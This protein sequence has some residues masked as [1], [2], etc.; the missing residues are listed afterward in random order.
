MQRFNHWR[1]PAATCVIWTLFALLNSTPA[2]AF[3]PVENAYPVG[4]P[5][6]H[7]DYHPAVQAQMT[8][9]SEP[10]RE[11]ARLEGGRWAVRWDELTGQA[12]TLLAP[13]ILWA[14]DD[15]VEQAAA[16]LLRHERLLGVAGDSLVLAGDSTAGSVR[17]LTFEQRLGGV[18]VDGAA[19]D[20]RLRVM[21]DGQH[22]SMVRNRCV[23]S[24]NLST[25]ASIDREEA[26]QLALADLA[27]SRI[28]V[29]EPGEL[30]IFGGEPSR[31][32]RPTLAWRSRVWLPAPQ[33]LV[34]YVDAH[35][36]ALLY[37]YDDVRRDLEGTVTVDYE[38][39][40]VDDPIM[41]AVVPDIVVVGSGG[42]VET[43]AAGLFVVPGVA[44]ED[45]TTSMMGSTI[46]LFDV[47]LGTIT[48]EDTFW[49]TV[50]VGNDFV[51]E[52]A[53][54]TVAARDVLAHFRIVR[55]YAEMRAPSLSWLHDAVPTTVN[56]DSGSCNAYY[57]NGTMTFYAEDP[58]GSCENFGRVSD[59]VYHEYGHGY[60]HYLIETGGFDGTVSEGSA[61]YL[62]STI[63]D[64]SYLGWGCY[65]SG[66]WIRE[67][68]T[69]KVYPVDLVGEVHTDGL[70]W[71]SALWDLRDEMI[72]LY[73]YESGVELNDQLFTDVLRG[74]PSLTET[75][76]ELILADDDNGDLTDGTPHLCLITEVMGNHGLGPGELGYFIYEH[77]SLGTQPGDATSYPVEASFLLVE[78]ACSDFD[79][80][81][82]TLYHSMDPAGPFVEV[83]L[84]WDG[85]SGYTGEIPRYP[86]GA[87]VYYYLM[88][89]DHDAV[90]VFTT[91]D[92]KEEDLYQFFVGTL[93]EIW[94][95]D[96]EFTDGL[97]VHGTGTP[98]APEG[99]GDD[100]ERAA[101]QGLTGDPELATSGT[102]VWG[103]DLSDDGE[104]SNNMTQYLD[105]TGVWVDD[106]ERV[107]LQ[108]QRWLT[109]EDGFY[110][111]ARIEVN[112]HVVWENPSTPGG[113]VHLIDHEWGL[114]DL[115][116]DELRDANDSYQVTWTLQSDQGLEYGGWTLDDVCFVHLQ[117][118][119]GLYTVD[120]FQASDFEEDQSTLT[121]TNPWVMPMWT[122]VVVRNAAHYPEDWMDGVM[123]FLDTD[124]EWGES[125][126]IVDPDLNPESTYYYAVFVADEEWS[127]RDLVVEGGNADTAITSEPGDDDSADDDDDDGADD[128]DTQSGDPPTDP[129]DTIES[130]CACRVDAG[131]SSPCPIVLLLLG[132]ILLRGRRRGSR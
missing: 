57:Y 1:S 58:G 14:Q 88:A 129:P 16:F 112:G 97:F 43:D 36:G 18:A 86:S 34:T 45:L 53:N 10:F 54:A 25:T 71:A 33:V 42:S 40:T 70:I 122:V 38:E 107:R 125:I 55:D 44:D 77:D 79:P 124:P 85:A 127:F 93:D 32:P 128:D 9:A 11:L 37:R 120:D 126:E 20:F 48:P 23:V 49:A 83:L 15:A 22:L 95:D 82:V 111:H 21:D 96:M 8:S 94:C 105:L 64:D 26:L 87:T 46:E 56:V 106:A 7:Q 110:D 72:G 91:H 50:G 75:Y 39:R 59:V 66:T 63:W 31:G 98:D 29:L 116:V 62:S 13:G 19:V 102:M 130:D 28:E 76:D 115:D 90:T 60:H 80:E 24:R 3:Q 118:L 5:A 52:D 47:S 68:D 12:H 119:E 65:G 73:G 99:G 6:R 109:V 35:S 89:M 61:D 30:V 92:G 121:W 41:T 132:G 108:Y 117:D 101:P 84:T 17:Y 113:G 114:H 67:I 103:T 4:P 27:P 81:S 78:P 2:A 123:V 131:G 69:D 104:Y 100:W 74:G 51:W